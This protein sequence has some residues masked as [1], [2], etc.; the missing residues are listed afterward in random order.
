MEGTVPAPGGDTLLPAEPGSLG[1]ENLVSIN[2]VRLTLVSLLFL[3]HSLPFAQFPYL[4]NSSSQISCVCLPAWV[5]SWGLY[6]VVKALTYSK[7]AFK[8]VHS[9]PLNLSL[10][11][12][13][14]GST[15]DHR[16]IRGNVFFSSRISQT[17]NQRNTRGEG[18]ALEK[19][20][21]AGQK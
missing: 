12:E 11:V 9:S 17:K 8:S 5:I 19:H 1:A 18:I 6:S 7:N 13:F 2:P 20:R 21:S 3:H 4:L 10:S 16:R 14:P 15:R